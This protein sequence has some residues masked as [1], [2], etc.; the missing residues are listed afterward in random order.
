MSENRVH[1]YLISLTRTW[2]PIGWGLLLTWLLAAHVIGPDLADAVEQLGPQLA[3]LL[4]A[5]VSCLYYALVRLIEPRLSRHPIGRLVLRLLIGSAQRPAYGP[6]ASP[7]Q[8]AAGL[9]AAER[10]NR[11]RPR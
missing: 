8:V 3:V 11:R 5:I 7:A 9:A 4:A 6:G 10:L 1:D 2:V